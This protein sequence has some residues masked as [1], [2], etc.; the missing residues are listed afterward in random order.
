MTPAA[1]AP[2]LSPEER[3][4]RYGWREVARYAP[5]GTY[6]GFDR[7]P[8]TLEQV[9]HPEENDIIVASTVHHADLTY[10]AEAC[11]S[12]VADQ[13]DALVTSD[14]PHDWDV[15]GLG[16]HRP[17]VT[18]AF[19]VR[20]RKP[21]YAKFDCAAEDTRPLL[22]IEV[23]SPSTRKTDI[24]WKVEDYLKAGVEWYDIVDR[25]DEDDAPTLIGRHREGDEWVRM[26]PDAE[27]RLFLPPI[28]AFLRVADGHLE[29]I[30]AA[31]GE[32]IG[33]VVSYR[34]E[35]AEL[36]R[37]AEEAEG[38]AVAEREARDA[39][40]AAREAAERQADADRQARDAAEAARRVAD[41]ARQAAEAARQ[42][43]ER[44]ADA[45]AVARAGLERQLAELRAH[46]GTPPRP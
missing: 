43:A 41:A 8:L 40:E 3:L 21:N 5:D 10:L 18:V 26:E 25:Q 31:T 13:D 32:L 34:R 35:R 23:V 45:E 30:D 6:L 27:G 1:A 15:P 33:D 22:V 17:D 46:F 29:V 9:L 42:A 16:H 12:Q 14:V 19:E 44:R 11:R 2:E 24:E 39:A 37:R 36:R 38:K 20:D 7:M 28:N 4:L